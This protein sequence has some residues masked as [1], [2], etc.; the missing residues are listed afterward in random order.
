MKVVLFFLVGVILFSILMPSS[1]AGVSGDG[2]AAVPCAPG[3]P[4][5]VPG[6]PV[7]DGVHAS[8]YGP[9]RTLPRQGGPDDRRGGC[10]RGAPAAQP[11]RRQGL[12][13]VA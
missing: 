5:R 4:A 8:T 6:I 12:G 7:S 3:G 1:L 11:A 10:H 9:A 13:E 2:G